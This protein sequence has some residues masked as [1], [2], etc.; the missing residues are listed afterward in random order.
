MAVAVEVAVAGLVSCCLIVLGLLGTPA[1][2]TGG[3]VG[4]GVGG[5]GGGA[6]RH[7]WTF[8]AWA[9]ELA[10]AWALPAALAMLWAAAEQLGKDR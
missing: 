6:G 5:G 8:S 4:V 7:F 10:N 1:V 2:V 9:A 3:G